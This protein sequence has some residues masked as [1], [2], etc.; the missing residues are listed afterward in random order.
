MYIYIYVY[1]YIYTYTYIHIYTYRATGIWKSPSDVLTLN[2]F[3]SLQLMGS[4]CSWRKWSKI[5]VRS[6]VEFNFPNI[7]TSK[8]AAAIFEGN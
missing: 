2:Q 3:L 8:L 5:Q 6:V 4:L 1:L 7:F